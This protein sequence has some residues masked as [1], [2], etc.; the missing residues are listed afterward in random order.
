LGKFGELVSGNLSFLN[1]CEASAIL[2]KNA[3]KEYGILG[4]PL[5]SF[6]LSQSSISWVFSAEKSPETEHSERLRE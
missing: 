3:A 1:P 2:L 5:M 6:S 4:N